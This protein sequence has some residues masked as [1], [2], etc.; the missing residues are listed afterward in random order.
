MIYQIQVQKDD[1]FFIAICKYGK[2][3]YV[4]LGVKQP[5]KKP[6]FLAAWGKGNHSD[7][8]FPLCSSIVGEVDAVIFNES[9]VR[10]LIIGRDGKERLSIPREKKV[11]YKAYGITYTEYLQFLDYI[12]ALSTKQQ[13]KYRGRP[14]SRDFPVRILKAYSVIDE[15]DAGDVILEWKELDNGGVAYSYPVNSPENSLSLPDNTCR[16]SAIRLTEQARQTPGMLGEGI[17]S[18]FWQDPPLQA[19]FQKG[20]VKQHHFY[21]LPRPP[22]AFPDITGEKKQLLIDIYNRLDEMLLIAQDSPSS[23]RKFKALKNLYQ[24]IAT[25]LP[26]DIFSVIE[27]I[28]QWESEHQALISTHRRWYSCFFSTKT[29]KMFNN[30]HERFEQIKNDPQRGEDAVFFESPNLG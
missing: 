25:Q 5:N 20:G 8:S 4:N 19:V 7:S 15:N 23:I 14:L 3:S 11:K 27:A 29:E 22:T 9:D 17:S 21:I 6:F 10:R 30:F 2:H 16:H 18:S 12:A 24:E 1:E 13:N 26:A 28:E